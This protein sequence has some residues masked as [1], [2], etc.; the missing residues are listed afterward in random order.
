MHAATHSV[1]SHH[2]DVTTDPW[3]YTS[4][5]AASATVYTQANCETLSCCSWNSTAT[6]NLTIRWSMPSGV[7]ER[8]SDLCATGAPTSQAAPTGV[9]TTAAPTEES[10]TST[11]ESSTSASTS[12]PTSGAPAPS[13]STL[14]TTSVV[15]ITVFTVC[16]V[17]G[18]G[19]V[20]R[21]YV[22][23]DFKP[24]KDMF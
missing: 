7:C 17:G 11:E 22:R 15:L 2:A 21:K 13:S 10:S 19:Y 14:S 9:P 16:I 6:S 23:G 1:R 4:T 12:S 5:C 20:V 3:A 8:S 24:D 18:L